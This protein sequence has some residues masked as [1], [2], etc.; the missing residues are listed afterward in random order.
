MRV[1]LDLMWFFKEH[2]YRYLSGIFMLMVVSVIGLAPPWVVGFLINKYGSHTLTTRDLTEGLGA[3]AITAVLSYGLRYG[4]RIYLYGGSIQLATELRT[5]LYT[6]FT[7][8]SPRFYHQKRIG[9]LMAHSTN[10]VQAVQETAGDGI[11]TLFDSVVTGTVVIVTMAVAISWKLTLLSLLP[12]PIIAIAMTHYG[13]QLHERFEKAQAAF[14]DINDRVQEHITG[15]RV[16]RAFGQ[17]A[18]ERKT[19]VE[20]SREVVNKNVAVARVDS[21]FDPTT[22]A[23]VGIAYFLSIA[24]GAVFVVHGQMNIGNLTTFTMYLGQLIWPMMAFGYL[25]NV[26]ERGS[27]SYGRINRLLSITSEVTDRLGAVDE[28]PSGD[29][30][31][32]IGTFAYP[33]TN[34]PSLQGVHLT[35]AQGETLGI[36]GRTGAGKSTLMRLLIREFDV[37]D[38]DIRIGAR[39]VYDV[40]LHGLRGAIAYAPQD[41]FLFS[42]T[43]AENIAFAKPDATRADVERVA[44]LASVHDDIMGFPDGYETVVGERGV[45]LSGGQKQRISIARALLLDSEVLLLDDTLSAVDARTETLILDE[46]RNNRANRTTLIATHRLSA[47]EHADHI[48]VLENGCIVERG[49]H[50]F[51]LAKDGWYADMFRRQQLEELVEQ[52]GATR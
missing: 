4:W 20:L 12:L 45:T 32:D 2:R 37:T 26:V 27:A 23:I 43:V 38:G 35:V 41:D 5:K 15:V 31:Y 6:H 51:L 17:E 3:I 48:I 40:T 29:I 16:V 9:D 22:S 39:S 21:M 14:S 8:M 42:A 13:R 18:W 52:G 19:F 50:A 44:R 1:F 49:T 46:L 28:V 47:V 10:D 7:R 33:E 36:V 24:V 11:L 30:V 34:S 25:F